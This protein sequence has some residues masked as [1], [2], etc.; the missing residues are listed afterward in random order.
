VIAKPSGTTFRSSGCKE[1]ES[2]FEAGNN[3]GFVAV[4]FDAFQIKIKKILNLL[5]ALCWDQIEL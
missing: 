3:T 2:D 1:E 4:G 5:A